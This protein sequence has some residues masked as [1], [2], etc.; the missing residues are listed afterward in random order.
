MVLIAGLICASGVYAVPDGTRNSLFSIVRHCRAGLQIVPSLRNWPS[1]V[2][3][4]AIVPPAYCNTNGVSSTAPGGRDELTT[5]S[6]RYTEIV[7]VVTSSVP[8]TLPF[9]SK[10]RFVEKRK[11]RL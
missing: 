4:R 7:R 6:P 10:P 3:H 9:N 1:P 8:S 5:H 11:H 2:G